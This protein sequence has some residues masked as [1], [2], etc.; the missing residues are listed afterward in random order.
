MPS[1]PRMIEIERKA[2]TPGEGL[3]QAEHTEWH[4]E[5]LRDDYREWLEKISC[6][7]IYPQGFNVFYLGAGTTPFNGVDAFEYAKA[8]RYLD[9]TGWRR[10][11]N[12]R[13][14]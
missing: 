4:K 6:G 2:S 10:P 8:I 5:L 9:S 7:V 11:M 14:A 12:E 3:S 1:T 13:P